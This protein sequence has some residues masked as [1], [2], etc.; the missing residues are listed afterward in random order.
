MENRPEAA[1]DFD[2]SGWQTA[3]AGRGGVNRGGGNATPSSTNVYRGTFELL[4][5]PNTTVSL[6]V[7]DLGESEWVYL[8]GRMVAE[9]VHRSTTGHE[10]KLAPGLLRTGTNV[11]A[12][13]AT[14][15]AGRGRDEGNRN[16]GSPAVAKI[17]TPPGEWKRSVFNGL[18][19]V[20]V[21]STGRPGE[22]T[23][24]ATASGLSQ[25]VLKLQTQSTPLR[26]AVVAR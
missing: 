9:N 19:Q 17:V 6:L 1:F 16:T 24:T 23:L 4:A 7:R 18:A 10:F 8:N 21:Q 22:I 15:R 13:I 11:L 25:G 26:P 20:I 14:P 5:G 3:F 12:L 2:D